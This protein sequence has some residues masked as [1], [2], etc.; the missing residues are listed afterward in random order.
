MITAKTIVVIQC[1]YIT[2]DTTTTTCSIS[3][4]ISL[5]CKLSP[6]TRC[7]SRGRNVFVLYLC[8]KASQMPP[9][10]H[11]SARTPTKT[12]LM[13]LRCVSCGQF[14]LCLCFIVLCFLCFVCLCRPGRKRQHSVPAGPVWLSGLSAELQVSGQPQVQRVFG[15][16]QRRAQSR[17][18][19]QLGA[20]AQQQQRF[21]PPL[22]SQPARPPA[23]GC[24]V[25]HKKTNP[26]PTIPSC[27]SSSARTQREPISGSLHT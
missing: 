7:T 8:T 20:A 4:S 2:C 18:L 16:H 23:W 5:G 21:K 12:R 1:L 14:E 22:P 13:R 6:I 17:A 11:T 10:M 15:E 3:C 27:I 26:A 25:D 24:C 19:P 9:P